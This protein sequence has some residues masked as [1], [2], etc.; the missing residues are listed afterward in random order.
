MERLPDSPPGGKLPSNK[1]AKRRFRSVAGIVMMVLLLVA[2]AQSVPLAAQSER[3]RFNVRRLLP[4]ALKAKDQGITE[5]VFIAAVK[6][7]SGCSLVIVSTEIAR[8]AFP[9][10]LG[11]GIEYAE[12]FKATALG[13]LVGQIRE[14][15]F[16]VLAD[17]ALAPDVNGLALIDEKW[18][19]NS[20]LKTYDI[21]VRAVP[22][23]SLKN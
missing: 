2:A 23:K 12:R 6:M 5:L 11:C 15:T 9:G 3:P 14:Y 19:W 20:Q 8:R 21:K 1:M 22:R 17:A 16:Y 13:S 18:T 10:L 7:P 4:L